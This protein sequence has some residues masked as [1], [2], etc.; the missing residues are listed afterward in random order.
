MIKKLF[1]YLK[2]A[3]ID[4]YLPAKKTGKCTHPYAVIEEDGCEPG[5]TGR[6]IHSRYTVTVVAPLESYAMLDETSNKAKAALRGTAFR[7]D[8]SE[9]TTTNENNDSYSRV[10]NYRVIKPMGCKN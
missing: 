9:A 1:S 3:G 4:T 2:N 5:L 10:L 6:C 8:G 7:F